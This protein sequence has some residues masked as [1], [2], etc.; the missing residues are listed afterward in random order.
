MDEIAAAF[1]QHD[2]ARAS[3]L[4]APLLKTIPHDPWV[5]LY[6]AKLYEVEGQPDRAESGYRMILQEVVSP[7]IALQARQGLMRLDEAA[8]MRRKE[9]IAQ[10]EVDLGNSTGTGFLILEPVS[11]EARKSIAQRFARIMKLDPYTAQLQLPSRDR[12]LYRRGAMAEIQTYAEE[13]H[14]SGIPAFAI[15][16]S[17]I[18]KLRVFRVQFL[19]TVTPQPMVVCKNEAGQLGSIQFDWAEVSRQ[20]R[21][22]LPIFEDVVDLSAQN[23]LTRKEK[24]QDYAQV[25]D[26]HLPKRHCILRICDQS[27]QFQDG[28]QFEAQQNGKTGATQST[29]RIRWNA[30]LSILNQ[31][32]HRTPVSTHFN[33]FA[34]T[35]L[36]HFDLVEPF[37]THIDL[38]RKAQSY[39]DDAFHVYSS[40]NL[41][42]P[43]N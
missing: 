28:I 32:L 20:V 41:L 22:M 3:Q 24:T 36:E 17:D 42:K 30:L 21:A 29:T 12:R 34:E 4:L 23:K 39:W 15:A 14:S 26:L 18:V 10:A 8:E 25:C 2:F 38:F 43:P 11:R 13:L 31:H 7:R 19:Q 9:A 5:R 6:Q 40:L 35:A 37:E 1:E 33:S 16:L 27:Y